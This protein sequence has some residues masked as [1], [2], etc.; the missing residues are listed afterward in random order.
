MKKTRITY[1]SFFLPSNFKEGINETLYEFNDC[2]AW[3]Y[4]EMP[5]L[6]RSLVKHRLPIKSEFHPFQQPPRKMSKEVELKVKEEIE[7]LL[8]AKFIRP[9]RYVQ[10]LSNIVPVTKR[11][12][13]LDFRDLNAATPKDMYAMPIT[14]MLVDS[15]TNNELLSFIDEYN[16]ILIAIDD[17]IKTVFRCLGSFGTFQ[18][19]VMPFGLK[20]A[21][22]T[23]QRAMN[24]ILHDML[25]HH[26][27]IYIDGI[28]VKS[29]KETK[30]VNHLRKSFERMRLHRLKH[31]P[32]KCVFGVRA[33]NFIGFLVHQRGVEVD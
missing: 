2:L 1:I 9:T 23:Y 31:N 25:G 26:M 15:T 21:G 4:D 30:H 17:I 29:K 10:W 32:L 11:M 6:N 16:Q 14:N 28:V 27:E 33:R 24:A 5:G 20:N 12:G 13:N 3:N 8:K 18:W 22:A 7:K 19:L